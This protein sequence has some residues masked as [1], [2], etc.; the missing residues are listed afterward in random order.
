MEA[1]DHTLKRKLGGDVVAVQE[2]CVGQE[3]AP[4]A[5][6]SVETGGKEVVAD[7]DRPAVLGRKRHYRLG[8]QGARD[9]IASER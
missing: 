3:N 2:V 6:E 5:A 4:G 8:R 1:K 9:R 7:S